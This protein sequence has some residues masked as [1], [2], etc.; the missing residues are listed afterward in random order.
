MSLL[1]F[2]LPFNNIR[3]MDWVII[4]HSNFVWWLEAE[5][6]NLVSGILR[7][8]RKK[9][10]C[11]SKGFRLRHI[12][13]FVSNKAQQCKCHQRSKRRSYGHSGGRAHI[14]SLMGGVHGAQRLLFLRCQP[15]PSVHV[16]TSLMRGGKAAESPIAL[17]QRL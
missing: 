4:F 16:L 14:R 15:S 7:G 5:A 3:K 9:D 13:T 17:G 8:I 2:H 12:H 6:V 10:S 1:D 11:A